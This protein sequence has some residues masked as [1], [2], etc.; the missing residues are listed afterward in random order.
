MPM[1]ITID[2]RNI[3]P[4]HK[5]YIIAEAADAHMGSMDYAKALVRMAASCGAD[6]IKFQHHLPDEEML[7]DSG[8]LAD[9]LPEEGL[10]QWLKTHAFTLDQHRE[11]KKLC[12]Q[13]GV[14]YLCT[15]FSWKA[16]QEIY[17]LVPA[18][19][20]GS[21]EAQ[22]FPTLERIAKLGKPMIVSTGMCSEQEVA[23][24]S[25]F[26]DGRKATYVLLHCVSEYPPMIEDLNLWC[27]QSLLS[28]HSYVG[29][30]SHYRGPVDAIM[31][32]ALGACV[33]E[34]HV[35]LS[36]YLA[37]PDRCVSM[38]A[39]EFTEV[40]QASRY[41]PHMMGAKKLVHGLEAPVR[42]W[43]YRSLVIVRPMKAGDTITQDDIWSKRPGTG[44][45]AKLMPSYIGRKV[46]VDIP[47]N[48]M[49]KEDMLCV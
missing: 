9:N 12:V 37:G 18:F 32:M 35:S 45:P 14:T 22:D 2:G 13:E 6:A 4:G 24:L 17:D 29:Y 15:P 21:G 41:L 26:L 49:L 11:I 25:L 31:A 33:I 43:A 42:A 3:G 7:P 23:G 20:I 28:Y 47:A 44:I 10:Y 34:K 1:T 16:A 30:S 39:D 38:N 46:T 48:T 36:E 5:P 19:K 27:I 40:V 8:P